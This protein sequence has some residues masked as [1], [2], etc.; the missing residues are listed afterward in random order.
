MILIVSAVAIHISFQTVLIRL[1]RWDNRLRVPAK[2]AVKLT[3]KNLLFHKYVHERTV[4]RKGTTSN[5]G[6]ILLI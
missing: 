2:P 6:G 1:F 5:V 3:L 4:N